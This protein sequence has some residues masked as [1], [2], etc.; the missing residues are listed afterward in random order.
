MKPPR[1]AAGPASTPGSGLGQ[2]A[3]RTPGQHPQ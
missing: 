2:P 1:G 3:R